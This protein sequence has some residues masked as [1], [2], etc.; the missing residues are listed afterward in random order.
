MDNLE[1]IKEYFNNDIFATEATGI[2]IDEAWYGHA[3]CSFFTD[4][5]HL[6]AEGV[7]MGGA[8]YT[9]CDISFAAAANF[10]NNPTV[11]LN[12]QIS[13]YAPTSA[14]KVSAEAVMLK[15]G[16]TVC[17]YEVT[18]TDSEGRKIAMATFT[19]FRKNK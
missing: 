13:F 16:K 1:E 6:N 11:T 7:V 10:Q 15:D 18:V 4:K 19:G 9:L 17:V 12:S 3:K 8:L 5:K 14:S 2:S